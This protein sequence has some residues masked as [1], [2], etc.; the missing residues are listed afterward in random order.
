MNPPPVVAIPREL[1]AHRTMVF[2][3]RSHDYVLVIPVL[4]EGERIRAQ[5]K[6]LQ[7]MALP[8]DIVI[9][10]GN[11][12]DGS[13]DETVLRQLGIRALLIKTG[14]G[15]LSAQLRMAYAW[16]LDEGY[17]GI[18][19]VDGNG[20]DGL[21]AISRFI[22]LLR[23]GYDYVQGSRYIRG[24]QAVNTPVDRYLAGRF[25]HAPL[26]SLA[27]RRRL[28]DTTNGFRGYSRRA[29]ED[30]RVQPF[31]DVFSAYNLLFYLSVRLPKLGFRTAE[32]PVR[33]CYP[34]EG[35]TPT[36]IRGLAG[37]AQLLV[38][39]IEVVRGKFD[40]V[41]DGGR[42]SGQNHRNKPSS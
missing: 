4:N 3:R 35:K 18:I 33:R 5:L 1:P 10:D 22:D 21:E 29:L 16:C 7:I 9:A 2:S 30:T 8:I 19:T 26:V 36:K 38:E 31:R 12:T 23:D 28:T 17:E 6:Q 42:M 27:A 40:P 20:K 25:I 37:K 34:T 24:G 15:R 32:T 11:S 41:D 14:P 39:L 13:M